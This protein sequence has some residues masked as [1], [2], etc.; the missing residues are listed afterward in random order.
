M[1]SDR[2]LYRRVGF[3]LSW[4]PIC[5]SLADKMVGT[6][7]DTTITRSPCT[8]RCSRGT[9]VCRY[10]AWLQRRLAQ[11]FPTAWKCRS[12]PWKEGTAAWYL[13]FYRVALMGKTSNAPTDD[14]PLSAIDNLAAHLITNAC[15]KPWHDSDFVGC[16]ASINAYWKR[17]APSTTSKHEARFEPSETSVTGP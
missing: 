3:F 5:T 9:G 11:R 13:Q 1:A 8:R 14:D 17:F 10:T 15:P 12:F 16:D 4:T 6:P 2:T 7:K